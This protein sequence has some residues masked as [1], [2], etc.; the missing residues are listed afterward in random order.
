MRLIAFLLFLFVFFTSFSQEKTLLYKISKE[1]HQES[2]VYGTMHI[3]PDSL[4]YFPNK[5]VN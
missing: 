5:L 1:G 3:L 2:Y 4:F